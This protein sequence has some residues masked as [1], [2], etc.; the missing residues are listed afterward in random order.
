MIRLL[1]LWIGRWRLS[2]NLCPACNSDAPALYRCPV[3][4][5]YSGSRGDPWPP[6]PEEMEDWRKKH[7]Q[8][9]E[10]GLL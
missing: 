9:V 2:W 5:G 1:K 3:C 10:Q 4:H 6:S 8:M 7:E